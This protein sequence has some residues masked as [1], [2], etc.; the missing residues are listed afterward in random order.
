MKVLLLGNNPNIQFYTSRFQSVDNIELF[1]VS[2]IKSHTFEVETENYGSV[3]YSLDNHFTSLKNL[4]EGLKHMS[5]DIKF[6]L[7]ILS[8]STLKELTTIPQLLESVINKQNTTILIESSG[9]L[10][11][12]SFVKS[13]YPN[14]FS[15]L[16]S[17]DIRE[18]DSNKYKQQGK[19]KN[20]EK[21]PTIILGQSSYSSKSKQS[22]PKYNETVLINLKNL[23]ATFKKIF[24][25]DSISTCKMNPTK[26]IS[27]QWSKA[28]PSICLDPLMILFQESNIDKFLNEILAKP[29]I[30]GLITEI[31]TVAKSTNTKLTTNMDNEN[32]IINT[33]KSHYIES[34]T[35][36]QLIYNFQNNFTS[37]LNLDLLLL[38]PILL[39]DDHDIKTPYLEFLFTVMIQYSNIN[40]D[41]SAWFIR[42]DKLDQLKQTITKITDEKQSLFN[43]YKTLQD[44][45][46]ENSINLET[47][48]SQVNDLNNENL[49]LKQNSDLETLQAQVFQLKN[50][51]TQL[52]EYNE[53]QVMEKNQIIN[54]LTCKLANIKTCDTPETSETPSQDVTPIPTTITND[55][56]VSVDHSVN[57]DHSLADK[58]KEL[59][60]KEIELK[61]KE[62]ELEK[63]FAYQQQQLQQQQQP[64][65]Q[66]LCINNPNSQISPPQ[67]IS[68]V[69]T[70]QNG[71]KPQQLPY[72]HNNLSNGNLSKSNNTTPTLPNASSARFVDP[73]SSGLSPPMDMND[74]FPTLQTKSSF[75]S[76]PIKPTSRKNRKSNMPT[77]GNASSIGFNDVASQSNVVNPVGRRISSMPVHG[78]NFLNNSMMDT[79]G[80]SR[81]GLGIDMPQPNRNALF[82]MNNSSSSTNIGAM[83]TPVKAPMNS[84]PTTKPIQFGSN[85]NSTNNVLQFN[86]NNS[87]Q[88][89]SSNTPQPPQPIQFGSASATLPNQSVSTT[90]VVISHEFGQAGTSSPL[91]TS[92]V[93]TTAESTDD[94]DDKK[95][96][97]K[98]KSKK[99]FGGLFK[100]NKK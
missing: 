70:Q 3:K 5:H 69:Y 1:H 71:M 53:R 10:P 21:N 77:I 9:F 28:I 4:V 13:K 6:D 50:E 95:G 96:K 31:L 87:T 91:P 59:L 81:Q 52:R 26:F 45:F 99:G 65:Q 49:Q 60:D 12:E 82:G 33:W 64:L 94:D 58:Q 16:S 22:K 8:A 75:G 38:Q 43:D 29:L 56:D 93:A 55:H 66:P 78:T 25:K 39:A 88:N 51:N 92:N 42:A 97:D 62:L 83:S 34:K 68:P 80:I 74:G 35:S 18:L 40:K 89:S 86:N 76:H 7:V 47:L 98:K 79:S 2:D 17:Y 46:Q 84:Q 54:D 24:Y 48:Q 23:E 63:K 67:N 32:H 27:E 19:I 72:N 73:I 14:V 100:R 20:S 57:T 36:P 61:R 90:P 30:S 15:I 85:S 37:I 41:K 44:D 11:L